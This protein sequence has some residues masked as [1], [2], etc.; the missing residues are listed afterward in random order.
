MKGKKKSICDVIV[1]SNRYII[2]FG[3]LHIDPVRTLWNANFK[4]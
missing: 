2:D 4:L 1:S 3:V